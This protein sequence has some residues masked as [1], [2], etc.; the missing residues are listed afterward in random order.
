[1][2]I[3]N[4]VLHTAANAL[5]I[6][7]SIVP[8]V[9]AAGV[10]V[11][12]I[13]DSCDRI[14]VC[15]HKARRMAK[16]CVELQA[17]LSEQ[18]RDQVGAEMQIKID[19]ATA[20][21]LLMYNN[22]RELI[23]VQ[24]RDNDELKGLL[25]KVLANQGGELAQVNNLDEPERVAQTL[26]LDGQMVLHQDQTQLQS[27]R[28]NSGRDQLIVADIRSDSPQPLP[29]DSQRYLEQQRQVVERGLAQL[30]Q[31]TGI[32]PSIKL[33]NGEVK[34]IGD[35]AIAGGTYSDIWQGLWLGQKKV[36]LKA[37]R[38]IK[39]N[40]PKAQ[41]R[42]EHEIQIWAG[43]HDD[44]ILPFYGIVTDQGQHIQM[45]SPWQEFGNVLE[46]TKNV[47]NANRI[48]LLLGAA[49]GLEYL[50]GENIIHG[51]VKCANILVTQEHEACICDFGMSKVIEDVTEKSASATLTASGSARWL[52]PE[53]IEGIVSSP[54]LAADTY[55][56]A[57]AMLELVT[58][59]H[60]FSNRR[61]DAS[62]IH[63]IV[64][65]KKIPIRPTESDVLPWLSD[66]L[67]A[68]MTECWKVPA[69][70]RPSMQQVSARIA[71]IDAG[72][73][74]AAQLEPIPE[75]DGDAMDTS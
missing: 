47:A 55:S 27:M 57:M 36:A 24:Q 11:R 17:L 69:G 48:R 20:A 26:M 3:A 62:V 58:G 64:V 22:Q 21:G 73:D 32:P 61:R 70:L 19:E 12:E 14:R 67:W 8:F 66:N 9:G 16:K 54:T 10:I 31:L 30:H 23:E 1:M 46:Y 65:L 44:H 39:A 50:H 5:E 29:N 56:Y 63:D 28:Q 33:M 37:L 49:K 6:A 68:L 4:T 60:P 34:R 53:L 59:K 18:S 75:T 2:P 41:K 71:E 45:V 15:K 72:V 35:L 40:D 43:L 51:N 42:F 25:I 38:N 74:K 13:S 52:A 7:G